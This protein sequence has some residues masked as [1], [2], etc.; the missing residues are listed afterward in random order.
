MGLLMGLTACCLIYSPMG[1]SSGAHYNPAVTYSFWRLGKI[2]GR[3]A[4]GYA[5]SQ[6]VGGL[7]GVWAA[8]LCLGRLLAIPQVH[9]IVTQ[10]GAAGVGAA[11]AAEFFETFALMS[12]VLLFLYHPR[13]RPYTGLVAASIL[14]AEVALL[15]PLSGTSLNPARS[16]ASA[17]PAGDYTSFWIYCTAPMLGMALSAE[18]AYRFFEWEHHH[19][20]GL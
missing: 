18:C 5:A 20:P 17:I 19:G 7:L 10:P 15:S 16:L 14:A 11:F 3:D 13:A 2:S 6:C 9:F 8:W 12:G 4:L 1:R